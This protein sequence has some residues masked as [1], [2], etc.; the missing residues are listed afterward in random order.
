MKHSDAGT[1][2]AREPLVPPIIDRSVNPISTGEGRLYPPIT[3]VF[4]LP[5]S[6]KH[7]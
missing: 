7:Q 3:I 1:G 5:A 4:H 6:L 2:G